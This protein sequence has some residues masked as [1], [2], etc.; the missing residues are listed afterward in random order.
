MPYIAPNNPVADWRAV[1]EGYG[2]GNLYDP[3]SKQWATVTRT[4]PKTARL[5]DG[6]IIDVPAG[7]LALEPWSLH[8]PGGVGFAPIIEEARTNACLDS[9]FADATITTRWASGVT[10]S[11][12]SAVKPPY[13]THAALCE[14][15]GVSG[16]VNAT[17]VLLSQVIA[18]SAGQN[19]T[20]TFH[21]RGAVNGCQAQVYM[22][23][24]DAAS[25]VLGTVAAN[26]TPSGTW[27][28]AGVTYSNLPTG[29]VNVRAGVRVTGVD[30]G[31]TASVRAAAAQNEL[32]TFP[33]SYIPTTTAAVTRNADTVTVPTTGWNAQRLTYVAVVTQPSTYAT[34]NI[35]SWT[36]G[37]GDRLWLYTGYMGRLFAYVNT[38]GT[39]VY[40]WSDTPASAFVGAGR[41]DGSLVKAFVDGG[42]TTG[43]A[44][45]APAIAS[46][47]AYVGTE[48]PGFHVYSGGIHRLVVYDRA[49]TDAQL[50]SADMT[51]GLIAGIDTARVTSE[52]AL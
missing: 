18:R 12:S 47:T 3:I 41:F 22:E 50:A 7:K 44:Y 40:A 26:V 28:R 20:Q 5:A 52:V 35:V 19:V 51:T 36:G 24:L 33:T 14:Y 42:G 27:A 29:T 37:S 10:L 15:T 32:G 13:G 34:S 1:P 25:A 43:T 45:T 48:T 39:I 11:R 4:T 6:T 17:K 31:D 30:A 21:V 8:Y 2:Y 49:L 23:A 16:D 38:S 9:Y 46:T